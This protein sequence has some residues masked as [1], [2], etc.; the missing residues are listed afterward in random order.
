MSTKVIRIILLFTLLQVAGQLMAFDNISCDMVAPSEAV[1]DMDH[2]SHA[3]M[4]HDMDKMSMTC[5][6]MSSGCTMA[7]CL[8][9]IPAAFSSSKQDSGSSEPQ[10]ALKPLLFSF[11]PDSLYKPPILS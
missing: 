10:W 9:I 6:D 11:Q 2:A 1:T 7:T 3:D 8:A 4:D 5:C